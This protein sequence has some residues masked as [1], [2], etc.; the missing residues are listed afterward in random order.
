MAGAG[1][2]YGE[3]F[4]E[5]L[6]RSHR[7]GLTAP[8]VVI[9]QGLALEGAEQLARLGAL[10]GDTLGTHPIDAIAG[11]CAPFTEALIAPVE[12]EFGRQAYFTIGWYQHEDRELFRMSET[13]IQGWLKGSTTGS[14]S[15]HCWLTL[16]TMEVIDSTLLT[17]IA[18]VTGRD[19][20]R[21]QIIAAHG[22]TTGLEYQPML[23]GN[24]L[25][26]RAG[27]LERS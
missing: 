20:L 2:T 22:D 8:E 11:Q 10:V 17:S 3:R 26:H 1:S 21:G 23:V 12:A 13:D 15:I 6:S 25:L 14:V 7:L 4:Q 24:D 19:S 9:E 27:W 5:A 18:K 16:S